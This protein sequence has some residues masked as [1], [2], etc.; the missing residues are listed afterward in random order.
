M[1]EGRRMRYCLSDPYRADPPSVTANRRAGDCKSKALWLF[2]GLGDTN[3]LFVIGKVQKRARSSHAWVYWRCDE[4]WW[5]LDCTER[6]DP[7]AAD[8]V[9]PDRYVAYYS[10]GK[11]HLQASC[12]EPDS[13]RGHHPER[14]AS[15]GEAV[16]QWAVFSLQFSVSLGILLNA[17]HRLPRHGV[18]RLQS[19]PVSSGE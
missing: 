8:S 10:F 7:I 14:L 6:G 4:R 11:R 16:T 19:R 13:E 3:A 15:G 1:K 18:P 17:E 5:I 12:D 9:G 2:D